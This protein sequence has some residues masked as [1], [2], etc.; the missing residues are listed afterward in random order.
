M[1]NKNSG[2]RIYKINEDFFNKWSSQMAYILGFTCADG[3]VYGRSL[4]WDLS[5]K[6]ESNL[7]AI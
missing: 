2:K 5:D 7:K 1:G 3:N 4:S 6:F